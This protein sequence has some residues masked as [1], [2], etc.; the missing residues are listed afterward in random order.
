MNHIEQSIIDAIAEESG[1][2]KNEIKLD[3]NLYA[4]GINSLSAL[5]ILVALEKKY[6][7]R[8]PEN[9]LNE[10]NSVKEIVKVIVDE[11]N[12]KDGKSMK[13]EKFYRGM[14]LIASLYDFILGI[15][16]FLFYK[17]IYKIFDIT[18]PHHPEYI[19]SPALFIA[20]LGVMLFY[21]Y[22]DMY[23][24]VDM[25]KIG[26]LSKIGYAGLSFYHYIFTG[27]HWVFALFAWCDLVFLVL[28]ILFLY[29]LK[30]TKKE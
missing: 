16:F 9:R 19:Q 11:L 22:K 21:V 10:A 13:G 18:L 8:I 4:V 23:R 24:N 27:P 28:F 14:F 7:I 12:K 20:I 25:V 26:I 17:Q 6:D 15:L 29:N 1:L 2:N 3:S 5:E 30:R